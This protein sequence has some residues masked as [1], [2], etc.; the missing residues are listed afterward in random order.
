MALACVALA[1]IFST[2]SAY[3][4]STTVQVESIVFGPTRSVIVDTLL[5]AIGVERTA[6][7]VYVLQR[8]FDALVVAAAL[9]PVFLWLLG[10]SAMHAAARLRGLRGHPFLPLLVLFGYAELVYQVPTSLASLALTG[11]PLSLIA[12][13]ASLVM[14][15]WFGL[16]VHRGIALH[17]GVPGD[18]AFGIFVLGALAFYLL[19]LLLIGATLVAIVV[20]AAILQY[21]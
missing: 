6:V 3:R 20:A 7:L 11:G 1:M 2:L 17:Y 15:I 14:L 18:R 4:L 21:F 9:T 5:V 10:S 19:P 16:V 13:V 8:S 12:D